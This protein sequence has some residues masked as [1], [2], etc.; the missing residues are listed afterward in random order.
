MDG[1]STG[2]TCVA[3]TTVT[4]TSQNGSGTKTSTQASM[5]SGFKTTGLL[6]FSADE[7]EHHPAF[8]SQ[9]STCVP[10]SE[11]ASLRGGDGDSSSRAHGAPEVHLDREWVELASRGLWRPNDL[12]MFHP[13]FEKRRLAT[14]YGAWN[15]PT[16]MG[17]KVHC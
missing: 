16:A 17:G 4:S 10:P 12:A 14:R 6:G 9:V 5:P 3:A 1:G 15:G 8:A 2:S 13:N 11:E 7:A